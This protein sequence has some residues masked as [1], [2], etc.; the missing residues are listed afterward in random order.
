MIFAINTHYLFISEVADSYMK[1]SPEELVGSGGVSK[2]VSF[3]LNDSFI[4]SFKIVSPFSVVDLAIMTGSFVLARLM[5]NLQVFFVA[6]PEQILITFWTI[7]VVIQA[8][9]SRLIVKL[10]RVQMF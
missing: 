9:V 7:Y 4:L 3:V 2:F 10:A 8:V 1:F 6:T 5:P